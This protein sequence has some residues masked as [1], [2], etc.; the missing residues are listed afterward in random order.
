MIGTMVISGPTALRFTPI[1]GGDAQHL[2]GHP[3]TVTFN[4]R[5]PDN[6]RN[7]YVVALTVEM[8]PPGPGEEL[9]LDTL[10]PVADLLRR[11]AAAGPSTLDIWSAVDGA[12]PTWCQVTVHHVDWR[13]SATIL[14]ELVEPDQDDES[15][16]EPDDQDD[17][18]V[19]P[20]LRV[21]LQQG[22]TRLVGRDYIVLQADSGPPPTLTATADTTP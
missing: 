18:H 5:D 15:D 1:E 6:P 8:A 17:G 21:T 2:D 12:T 11:I 22:D 10:A 4:P 13:D 9:H 20:Y 14:V 7:G 3:L 16:A 19:P